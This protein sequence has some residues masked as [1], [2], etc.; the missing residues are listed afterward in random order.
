M[1]KIVVLGSC[2]SGEVGLSLQANGPYDV[3]GVFPHW[4]SDFIVKFLETS[5]LS[6]LPT[7]HDLEDFGREIGHQGKEDKR[8]IDTN[9]RWL[10]DQSRE[11]VIEF[12]HVIETCDVLLIDNLYDI[13]AKLYTCTLSEYEHFPPLKY[14]AGYNVLE[15][16]TDLSLEEHLEN[17]EKIIKFSKN[18]NPNINI[19]TFPTPTTGIKLYPLNLGK[20]IPERIVERT[21]KFLFNKNIKNVYKF[22]LC[23]FKQ[24][25]VN[26]K[27]GDTYYYQA[28]TD[29]Y[30]RVV[31]EALS[32][33]DFLNSFRQNFDNLLAIDTKGN[34]NES[35]YSDLPDKNFWKLAVSEKFPLSIEGLYVKKFAIDFETKIATCGSCFAQHIS[36]R[37]FKRGYNFLDFEKA[38]ENLPNAERGKL[39]YGLY[40][41]R[42]GNIYTSTQLLQLFQRAFKQR[43]FNEVWKNKSGNFVDPFRPNLCGDGYSSL[44]ELSEDRKKH[45]SRV[46]EMFETLD[47]LVVTMGLT[48]AWTNKETGA[49][50]PLCPGVSGGEFDASLHQFVNLDYSLILSQMELFIKLL[51]QVNP[52]AKLILTVSPVPLTATAVDRH[53]LVSTMASKSILRA[54]ADRLYISH[55]NVDYFPSYDMV[56]SPPYK[57]MF[58]KNN[59]REIHEEGVDHIMGQFFSEHSQGIEEVPN[60]NEEPSRRDSVSNNQSDSEIHCDEIFLELEKLKAQ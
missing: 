51:K 35:P 5:N 8:Y 45:L 37:L 56:M 58:F 47:V 33:S 41:A 32:G 9:A 59:L 14:A 24:E 53:V 42:Y 27:K 26:I 48:E 34:S 38:P 46:R 43:N 4:R 36:K 39:G 17:F 13:R 18:I 54:V 16:I 55:N 2:V 11:K 15:E 23:D 31:D 6:Y 21:E 1:K 10:I 12:K 22:P 50:Y 19:F 28:V 49:V 20:S 30:G 25:Y 57:G 7:K 60:I 40:S 44:E 3:G 52:S 29:A